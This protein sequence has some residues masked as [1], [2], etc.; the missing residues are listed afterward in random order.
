MARKKKPR[1]KRKKP[2]PELLSEIE[3]VLPG[4]QFKTDT[5]LPKFLRRRTRDVV[6]QFQKIPT[7]GISEDEQKV[8][9]E[10]RNKLTRDVV[11]PP[12][13]SIFKVDPFSVQGAGL[14]IDF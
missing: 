2:S 10:E 6:Q 11:I 14:P 3:E 9:T 8:K 12:F 7:R 13:R 1:K 4:I 5:T